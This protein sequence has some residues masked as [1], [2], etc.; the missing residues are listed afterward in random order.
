ME[1]SGFDIVSKWILVQATSWSDLKISSRIKLR[2]YHVN[3][4]RN[5]ISLK[6]TV[7]LRPHESSETTLHLSRSLSHVDPTSPER[8]GHKAVADQN[9]KANERDTKR[10]LIR[11]EKPFHK[12]FQ[13]K[14]S[15]Q[16]E[17]E[18]SY[19]ILSLSFSPR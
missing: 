7:Y 11:I 8:A 14:R 17:Y 5:N 10:L 13:F 18:I 1:G 4:D 2:L 15:E 16:K 3:I 6:E 12:K 9:W 19:T